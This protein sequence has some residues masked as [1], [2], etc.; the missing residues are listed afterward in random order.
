MIPV[1]VGSMLQFDRLIQKLEDMAARS[2]PQTQFFAQ[3]GSGSYEPKHMRF[4]RFAACEE[5][6]DLVADTDVVISHA[7]IGIADTLKFGMPRLVLPRR[8]GRVFV[9]CE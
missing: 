5:F 2:A 8:R 3:I 9:K 1:T 7:S 4:V 6:G